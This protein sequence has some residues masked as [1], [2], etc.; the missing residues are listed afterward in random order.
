MQINFALD[1]NTGLVM[2]YLFLRRAS[3][4]VKRTAVF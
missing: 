1:P 4:S 2:S 3:T